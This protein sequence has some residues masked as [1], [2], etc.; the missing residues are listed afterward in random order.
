MGTD[1]WSLPLQKKEGWL[2][3]KSSG[4]IAAW[5]RRY[6]YIDDTGLLSYTDQP[7][8]PNQLTPKGRKKVMNLLTDMKQVNDDHNEEKRFRFSIIS[9]R[10]D[11]AYEVYADTLAEKV[12]WLEALASWTRP[13]KKKKKG[14]KGDK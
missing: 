7:Q 4:V 11:E 2:T 3:K 6:F 8:P 14:K 13:T 1:Y 12:E 10:Y 9:N 5:Q